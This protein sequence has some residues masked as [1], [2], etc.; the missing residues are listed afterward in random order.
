MELRLYPPQPLPFTPQPA[1]AVDS[2]IDDGGGEG[3]VGL[4]GNLV[5]SVGAG[6]VFLVCADTAIRA[7]SRDTEMLFFR[8][9]AKY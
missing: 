1:A 5:H 6:A 4:E 8:A 2:S 7:R 9:T 3:D